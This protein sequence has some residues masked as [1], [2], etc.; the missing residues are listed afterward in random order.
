MD[1]TVVHKHTHIFCVC[2]IITLIVYVNVHFEC[3]EDVLNS[4]WQHRQKR[5]LSFPLIN[6]PKW[7]NSNANYNKRNTEYEIENRLRS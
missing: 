1:D 2:C 6:L 4:P 7:N 3:I 5:L